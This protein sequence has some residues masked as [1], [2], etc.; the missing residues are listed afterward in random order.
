M[1]LQ[2][3]EQLIPGIQKIVTAGDEAINAVISTLRELHPTLR[4]VQLAVEI[5][6]K[7]AEITRE[8]ALDII[9][10]VA[11]LIV[12]SEEE[13]FSFEETI[14]S[15]SEFIDK[16]ENF[17]NFSS[18]ELIRFT[19]RLNDLLNNSSTL[20]KSYRASQLFYEYER[21]FFDA[22]IVTDIRPLF[23]SSPDA[24]NSGISAVTVTHTLKIQYRDSG[25]LKEFYVGL[26]LVDLENLHD[27]IVDAL[28][29]N[30]AI[31]SMLK[32]AKITYIDTGVEFNE[33]ES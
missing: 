14:N 9:S 31:K 2:I 1:S 16:N 25:G 24:E 33:E 19:K 29:K 22:K 11:A 21:I 30:K 15:I 13:G 20:K 18:D 4:A 8:D 27:E 7:T 5:A 23:S 17:S 3:P 26:D 32:N 10:T 28:E 6:T 12:I